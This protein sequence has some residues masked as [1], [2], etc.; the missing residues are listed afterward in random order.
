MDSWESL[1]ERGAEHGVT[2]E[3]VRSALAEIRDGQQG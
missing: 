1:F 2:L 3:Q